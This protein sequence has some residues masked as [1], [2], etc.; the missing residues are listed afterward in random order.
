MAEDMEIT[1]TD[2]THTTQV[3]YFA[4]RAASSS[5]GGDDTPKPRPEYIS[6]KKT[7]TSGKAVE[8]AQ[9]TFYDQEG[10]AMGTAIS[11]FNGSFRIKKPADGTYT[12]KETKE[13]GNPQL[14]GKGS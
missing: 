6:F 14:Y 3:F 7:D 9:F 11:D 4:N 8:G 12:F 5:G 13:S 10:N 1:V 2:S